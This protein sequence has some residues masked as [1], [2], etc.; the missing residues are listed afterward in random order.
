[1]ISSAEVARLAHHLRVGDRVIEKDYVLA[2]LLAAI[3]ESTLRSDLAFKGG[4]A[5]KRCYYPDYRFS[6]DLDF[7]L[8]HERSHNDLAEEFDSLFPWL[9]RAV[10]LTLELHSAE[11]SIFNSSTLLINYV[12][13]LRAQL[14]SRRLKVD[15]TRNE[16]LLYPLV[17]RPLQAPY[18]DYP[19]HAA[20]PTYSL[21]EIIIEKLCALIGR[22]EPRDLYD[23]YWLLEW[24]D[25][26]L[27]W[28][29]SSF[30]SKCEHKGQDPV[31]L[32]HALVAKTGTFERLWTSRLAVQ[33]PEL[34]HLD[35]VLRAVRRHARGLGL[36]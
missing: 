25:V 2:W 8:C 15:V 29:P 20:L 10:N 35:E 1:M 30:R 16:L 32:D 34:P 9:A 7:T 23:V 11:Q 18:S 24:G 36:V 22:T 12:G 5:L 19:A 17:D 21:E 6:E 33:V 4:T 3:A 31:R 14:G 26:D 13:P 27:S 28:V